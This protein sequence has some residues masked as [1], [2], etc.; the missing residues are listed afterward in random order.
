MDTCYCTPSTVQLHCRFPPKMHK[1]RKWL[2]ST[3]LYSYSVI[4]EYPTSDLEVAVHI[5]FTVIR[6]WFCLRPVTHYREADRKSDLSRS[7]RYSR[8]RHILPYK[9]NSSDTPFNRLKLHKLD[10]AVFTGS[11]TT[12]PRISTREIIVRHPNIRLSTKY[13]RISTRA[14]IV[15]QLSYHLTSC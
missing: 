1:R 5:T 3:L 2:I 12:H 8:Y 14:I 11:G 9:R 13:H 15:R 4:L 6:R 7:G 10:K